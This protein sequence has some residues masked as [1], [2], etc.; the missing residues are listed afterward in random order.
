MTAVLARTA[1][2]PSQA[3]AL[4]TT[5]TAR[6]TEL[7]HYL[8]EKQEHPF[9]GCAAGILRML[10]TPWPEAKNALSY[11]RSVAQQMPHL[12]WLKE[13]DELVYMQSA[14]HTLGQ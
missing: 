13:T 12:C 1:G 3:S 11:P 4:K 8:L 9:N 2:T 5:G 6:L 14:V 10:H 7:L